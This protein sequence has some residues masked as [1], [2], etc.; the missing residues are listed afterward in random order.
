MTTP[1]D[2]D[3]IQLA[4]QAGLELPAE[5]R[6]ELIDAYRHVRRM[7]ERLSAPRPHGDEPA[8]TFVPTVFGPGK[9]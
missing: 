9:E 7:A 8:H 2:D 6:S 3:I 5:Y 4:H 1:S